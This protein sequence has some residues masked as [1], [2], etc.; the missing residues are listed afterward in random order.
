MTDTQTIIQTASHKYT[1]EKSRI[2]VYDGFIEGAN[3]I[4]NK[5]PEFEKW[6]IN[7]EDNIGKK[8]LEKLFNEFLNQTEK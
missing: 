7:N 8:P 1:V 5:L 2:S 6:I 3:F 4:L